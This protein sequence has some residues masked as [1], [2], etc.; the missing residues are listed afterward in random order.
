MD[1]SQLFS[2]ACTVTIHLEDIKTLANVLVSRLSV[3][4]SERFEDLMNE[5]FWLSWIMFDQTFQSHEFKFG[6]ESAVHINSKD[7]ISLKYHFRPETMY[8]YLPKE[9]FSMFPLTLY[10]CKKEGIIGTLLCDPFNVQQHLKEGTENIKLTF[11]LEY[12]HWLPFS[13]VSSPSSS[14]P[15][16]ENNFVKSLLLGIRIA[17]DTNYQLPKPVP[18]VIEKQP[19]VLSRPKTPPRQE[20]PPEQPEPE[21]EPETNDEIEENS[22]RHFKIHL[23]L[24][25][26]KGLNHPSYLSLQFTYPYFGITNIVKTPPQYFPMKHEMKIEKGIVSYELMT[27]RARLKEILLQYPLKLELN[28]KSHLGNEQLGYGMINLIPVLPVN[29]NNSP[30]TVKFQMIPPHSFR[31]P[32]T[33]QTFNNI[34]DYHKHYE[35]LLTLYKQKEI[36]V[37]PSRE[38]EIIF[39]HEQLVDLEEYS[40]G[41]TINEL[42]TPTGMLFSNQSKLRVITIIEDKGKV[43]KEIALK[44]GSGYRQQNG[45]I[46][47]MDQ[48]NPV[49]GIPSISSM[50][51]TRQNTNYLNSFPS[52]IYP[53]GGDRSPPSIVDKLLEGNRSPS[54]FAS[55]QSENP[56]N[57]TNNSRYTPSISLN[58]NDY[59]SQN[60]FIDHL[61]MDWELFRSKQENEWKKSLYEKEIFLKKEI[62]KE[63]S[64]KFHHIIDDMKRSKQEIS[65]LEVRLK[66]SLELIE[67]EKTFVNQQKEN[68]NNSFKQ[69]SNELMILLKKNK[70]SCNLEIEK[71]KNEKVNLENNNKILQQQNLLLERKLNLLQENYDNLY[72]KYKYS[73]EMKLKEEIILLKSEIQN[74]Q[75]KV[76]QE[77][78]LKE[79]LVLEKEYFRSQMYKL[80]TCL[81]KERE[82]N[83]IMV[84]QELEHL[85]LE[86]LARE[87]R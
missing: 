67:K 45:G 53:E 27:T 47:K 24:Y 75:E 5:T 66:T 79:N 4:E 7:S 81:K 39:A 52:T 86:F 71:Y 37:L 65:K 9:I 68:L 38:P 43:G 59:D 51:Q 14:D 56:N 64:Q 48:S 77:L 12:E 23:N 20:S 87:E 6:P 60:K 49:I 41:T 1:Q 17:V 8:S 30:S 44:V 26:L 54:R 11:P 80:A 85:R 57:Y 34:F 73:N 19:E 55:P 46:Y 63:Y 40:S 33:Q 50:Q 15:R 25:S 13:P 58:L 62:E 21:E 36:T 69:K 76:N 16:G 22:L 42:S 3:E 78:K 28:Q 84:K 82:K 70:L 35:K 83:N 72:S 18:P 61:L 10:L 74:S 31:C 32:I 2:A 29:S